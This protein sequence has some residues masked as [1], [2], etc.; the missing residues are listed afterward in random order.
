MKRGKDKGRAGDGVQRS[1]HDLK[2]VMPLMT[3]LM[4]WLQQCFDIDSTAV[5]R[6][7]EVIKVI[8]EVIKITA[9]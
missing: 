8:N 2:L 7:F 5:R 1:T 3:V 6:P 9:T 4:P